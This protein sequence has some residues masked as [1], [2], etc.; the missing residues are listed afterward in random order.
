VFEDGK[1]P[2]LRAGQDEEQVPPRALPFAEVD[3]LQVVVERLQQREPAQIPG[4]Q[5]LAEMKVLLTEVEK[6][7][8]LLLTRAADIETRQLHVLDG[9]WSMPS[10]LRAQGSSIDSAGT[11]LARRLSSMPQ[12]ASALAEGRLSVAAATTVAKSLA[13]LRRHVDRPDALIDGQPGDEVLTAVVVDGVLDVVCEARGGL[14]DDDPLLVWLSASLAEIAQRPA[15]QLA[16]L[17]A[18]LV[19]VARHV[20]AQ[21]LPSALARLT[22]AL[23]PNELERR[24]AEGGRRRAFDLRERDDGS[25]Y[26][27]RG[28]L[29]LECGE[30]L[31]AVLAAERAVDADAAADTRAWTQLRADGWQ[32]GD[33][34]P[35]SEPRAFAGAGSATAGDDPSDQARARRD[36]RSRRQRDHDALKNGLRRYLDSGIAGLRDKVAP[37]ICVT[38]GLDTLHGAPGALPA[39]TAS[40]ADVPASLLRTWWC[41]S[42]VTRFVLSLGRKVIEASHTERTL[43]PHERRAKHL[44]AGGRCQRANCSCRPGQRLVPHHV[45]PWSR[46]GTTSLAETALICELAHHD[47][48]S[49]RTIVLRDGRWLSEGGWV[50]GPGRWEP[51]S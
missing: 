39:R 40:G 13:A 30:L 33:D 42:A 24:V 49:G 11:T 8:A 4:P 16:R 15:S 27:C 21:L 47:V 20:E 3:V 5:A 2:A 26:D 29:D 31:S 9:G 28:A 46:C 41:Q 19:V 1:G 7:N 50:D 45:Q 35:E 25:G 23:L 6:L 34:V 51:G 22:D 38:V 36:P 48:H 10:W 43:R 17:E 44:E 14:A 12:V 32:P 37:H 18:A